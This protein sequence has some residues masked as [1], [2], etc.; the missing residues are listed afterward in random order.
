[1]SDKIVQPKKRVEHYDKPPNLAS[2][3]LPLPEEITHLTHDEQQQLNKRLTRRLDCTVMP[4]VFVLF[5]LNIL[6]RNNIASAKITGLTE[7]LS[8]TDEQY[9]TCLLM[10]YLGYCITQVPSNLIIGKVRPSYYICLLTSLWGVLSLTQ[11]F[12]KN[13]AQLASIRVILGLVEAPFLPAVF[14]LLSCWYTRAELPPRI[15]ILYGGNMLA[16]AFSGLIAAGITAHM[17]G[18]AGRPSWEWLFIIEGS[19][20]VVIALLFLPVL[21]DYPLQSKH[22]LISREMQLFA[23]W[24]IRKE[25][26]GIIDEDPESVWWGLKQALIDPKLYMFVIMQMSLITAESFSN[27]FP[28]IVGTL[29]YGDTATLLL[30][31]PPYFFAFFVSLAVSLHAARKQERGYHIA[32]PMLFALLGNLLAMFVPST[33]G[34]YFSMFLMTGGSYSPYN[35][36]VSW[37]SS[38]L[39]RPRAKRAAALAIMNFMGA[40]VAHFY[41]AYMFP[42]NQAPRYYAGGGVMSGACLLCAG[43]ALYIKFYLKKQNSNFE[44]EEE[45]GIVG[46]T[47]VTGSKVGHGG[48]A[49]VSFRYVH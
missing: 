16:T 25:N 47:Q 24:R 42:D 26:A 34:R 12:A 22:P 7:T 31:S 27:F 39:P 1:M 44:E 29:G 35:L 10:F 43:M 11:G 15:A 18:A 20:T 21:T 41:T 40:G 32:I 38:S 28:S 33:G 19:M 23:E 8:I 6:D 37:V 17:D 46:H 5:L 30:T 4:V 2:D 3:D 49:V 13:F 9:N 48:D 14:F 45:R 36:C